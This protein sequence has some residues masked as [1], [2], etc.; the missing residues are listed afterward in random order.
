MTTLLC[1]KRLGALRPADRDAED[2]LR[3][4][5]ADQDLRVEVRRLRRPQQHRLYWA[6]VKIVWEHQERYATREQ[7]HQALKVAVGYYDEI[8]KSDGQVIAVPHSI[9]FGN[10]PQESFEEFFDAVIRFVVT[11]I[12]PGTDDAELRRELEEMVGAN[13]A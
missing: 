13:A 12:L 4:L 7:L 9:A 6:L 2:T 11:K 1:R 5:P 8:T 10:M 3:K